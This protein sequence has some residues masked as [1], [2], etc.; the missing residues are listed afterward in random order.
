MLL[1]TV[2]PPAPVLIASVPPLLTVMALVPRPV[3]LLRFRVPLVI[4]VAPLTVLA[5]DIVTDPVNVLSS[6]IAPI[7]RP[8]AVVT[9]FVGAPEKSASLPLVHVTAPEF[10]FNADVSHTPLAVP[11]HVSTAACVS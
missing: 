10:Q 8:V 11:D 3:L 4:V 7:V 1:A 6:V 5:P 2:P 9:L